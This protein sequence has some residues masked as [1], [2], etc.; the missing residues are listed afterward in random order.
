M[1]NGGAP[2]GSAAAPAIFGS[3]L[4]VVPE[5]DPSMVLFEGCPVLGLLLLL[6]KGCG[7]SLR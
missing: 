5:G 1:Y 2:A 4:R 7:E 3:L 6:I